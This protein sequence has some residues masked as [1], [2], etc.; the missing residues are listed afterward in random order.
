MK[1]FT[2]ISILLLL[3]TLIITTPL[4]AGVDESMDK[5]IEYKK[6]YGAVNPFFRT[7]KKGIVVAECW[8]A[9]HKMWSVKS[10]I[11]F[12]KLIVPKKLKNEKPK[13]ISSDKL[14]KIYKFSDGTRI[15]LKMFGGKCTLV[16]IYAPNYKGPS[17]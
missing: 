8:N 11:K 14:E 10:S 7:N 4:L 12:A 2:K 3:A 15:I 1:F 6:K 16:G 17:C 9:P 13:L 5:V